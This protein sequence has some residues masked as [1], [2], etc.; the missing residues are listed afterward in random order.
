M[1]ILLAMDGT[2]GSEAAVGM[3]ID[4]FRP[5][6][7]QVRVLHAV[8]WMKDMPMSFEFGQGP[9]YA[10]DI[11]RSRAASYARAEQLVARVAGQLQQAGF[12]TSVS[13]P[14]DDPR[15]AILTVK[16]NI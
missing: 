5:G 12:Q 3:L 14:D 2:E 11:E 9:T 1:N 16:G 7:A 13:T 6:H 15:H 10:R 8:E 4:R